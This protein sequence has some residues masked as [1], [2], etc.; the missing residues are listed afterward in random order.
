MFDAGAVRVP[1]EDAIAGD[2]EPAAIAGSVEVAS[3]P[4][5]GRWIALRGN[6]RHP[7]KVLEIAKEKEPLLDL[8]GTSLRVR[9]RRVRIDLALTVDAHRGHL[10]HRRVEGARLTAGRIPGVVNALLVG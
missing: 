10:R 1:D 3:T 8:E 7:V 4:R 9:L 6:Q 5:A 2:A